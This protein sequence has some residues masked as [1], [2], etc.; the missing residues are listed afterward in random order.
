M[1]SSAIDFYLSFSSKSV[2]QELNTLFILSVDSLASTED[3]GK[4]S[5][6]EACLIK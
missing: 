1:F 5:G 6:S 2:Y 4:F 3:A